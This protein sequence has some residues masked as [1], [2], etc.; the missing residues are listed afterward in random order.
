MLFLSGSLILCGYIYNAVCIDIESNFNLRNA[1]LCR[2]DTVQAELSQSFIISCKL[3]FTLYDVNVHSSLII[4]RGREDLR[5][6]GRNGCVSLNQRCSN[7]SECF[8]RK[9]KRCYIEKK[10]ITR[11]GF[12]T[13]LSAL[14]SGTES[15][16]LIRVQV[17]RRLF[18]GELFYLLLHNRH[19][20]RTSNQQNLSK[21]GR[22]KAG[23]MQ[24]ILYRNGGS[25]CQIRSQLFELCTRKLHIEMLR[26]FSRCG[27]ERKVDVCC[28]CGRKLFL[29]LLCRFL[30][31]L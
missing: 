11:T 21:I 14:Y 8:D 29:C 4:S 27:N 25:L 31:T 15:H 6:S 1:A 7:A 16:A 13:Q 5:C 2:K 28:C 20:G 3:S 12:S 19:S 10:H 18:S 24:R 9:R 17:L 22:S 23:I 26:A 30:Q